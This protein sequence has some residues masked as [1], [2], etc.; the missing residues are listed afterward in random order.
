MRFRFRLQAPLREARVRR[1]DRRR[2]LAEAVRETAQAEEV[3]DRER[4]VLT[5]TARSR[6]QV[7]RAGCTGLE[8][9]WLD[10]RLQGA[11]ERLQH[12]ETS[13]RDVIGREEE[14][15]NR[16]AD[17]SRRLDVL[18]QIR[19]RRLSEH[20]REISR[21]EQARIDEVTLNRYSTRRRRSERE[22]ER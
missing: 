21:R 16:L 4:T 18:E 9:R 5:E 8:L 22:E 12:A 3:V 13:A 20:R 7:T 14:A 10:V 2:E 1:Q 19:E 15:R 17:A 11:R 6:D